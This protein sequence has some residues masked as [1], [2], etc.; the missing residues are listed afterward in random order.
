M[1]LDHT[2]GATCAVIDLGARL[3]AE[4]KDL[5]ARLA[6]LHAQLLGADVDAD[7]GDDDA[8]AQESWTRLQAAAL[9]HALEEVHY[10]DG[11]PLPVSA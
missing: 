8:R 4:L 9:R 11:E 5:E 7:R 2:E 6:L 10:F 1:E 3:R